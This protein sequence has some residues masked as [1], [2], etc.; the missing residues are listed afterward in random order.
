MEKIMFNVKE[1]PFTAWLRELYHRGGATYASV[2]RQCA[3]ARSADWIGR[4]IRSREPWA[5]NPPTK[6]T[7]AGF[8]RAFGVPEEDVRAAIAREWYQVG[9]VVPPSP[10]E[11]G[12]LYGELTAARQGLF[13]AFALELV[14][15]AK[16]ASTPDD[17]EAA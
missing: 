17:G 5:V 4:L 13:A 15:N 2:S 12:E 8:A 1:R 3:H 16:D 7:F 10:D 11:I 9:T 14:A 6:E